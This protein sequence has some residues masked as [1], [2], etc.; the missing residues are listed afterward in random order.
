MLFARKDTPLLLLLLVSLGSCQKGQQ[1]EPGATPGAGNGGSGSG[2]GGSSGGGN[3]G[4]GDP[5]AGNEPEPDVARDPPRDAGPPDPAN[6]RGCQL[7][8]M[9]PFVP[10][11]GQAIFSSEA[12]AIKLDPQAY[13]VPIPARN[14]TH[15]TFTI[16]APGNYLVFT[17]A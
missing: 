15:V 6:V 2:N 1:E 12:P 13:R 9:G 7:L 10:V 14:T 3:N 17:S 11:M 16:P 4:S 8:Q 5:D